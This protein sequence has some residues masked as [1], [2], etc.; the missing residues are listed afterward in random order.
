VPNIRARMM[1]HY[2]GLDERINANLLAYETALRAAGVDYQ[3]FVYEGVNHAF[4]N[5]TSTARHDP[6][7]ADLAWRRTIDFLRETLA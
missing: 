7:A 2:A 3:A 6:E 4:N 5:D 1:L